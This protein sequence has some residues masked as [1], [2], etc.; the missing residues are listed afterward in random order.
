MS[1]SNGADAILDDISQDRRK[2]V[3]RK[4]A[5]QDDMYVLVLFHPIHGTCNKPDPK[6]TCQRYTTFRVRELSL[7]VRARNNKPTHPLRAMHCCL[8]VLFKRTCAAVLV[9]LSLEDHGLD[10]FSGQNIFRGRIVAGLCHIH[11]I[12]DGLQQRRRAYLRSRD[13]DLG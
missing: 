11:I 9:A 4:I 3:G 12:P 5:L 2:R 7:T 6:C 8:S 1:R 13:S 10:C